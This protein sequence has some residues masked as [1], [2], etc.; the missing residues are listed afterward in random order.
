M[1]K[2]LMY[3][4]LEAFHHPFYANGSSY[5]Q[6]EMLAEMTTWIDGLGPEQMQRTLEALTKVSQSSLYSVIG[7]CLVG[8]ACGREP[9]IPVPVQIQN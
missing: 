6:R 8:V 5:I 3:W 4:I 9:S 1:L 2:L 7:A